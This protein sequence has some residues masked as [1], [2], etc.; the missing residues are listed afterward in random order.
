M[1]STYTSHIPGEIEES[2]IKKGNI[3]VKKIPADRVILGKKIFVKEHTVE[4]AGK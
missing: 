1:N 2:R 3:F 4:G